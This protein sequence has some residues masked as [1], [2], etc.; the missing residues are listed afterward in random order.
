[1]YNSLI[2]VSP[3]PYLT[4]VPDH[5][6]DVS[7]SPYQTRVAFVPL[8][9]RTADGMKREK[10]KSQLRKENRQREKREYEYND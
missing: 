10:K 3:Q 7:Q 2:S 5:F 9:F 4:A 8:R 1:M 6:L